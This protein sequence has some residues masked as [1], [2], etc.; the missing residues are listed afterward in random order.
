MRRIGL[1]SI[2]ALVTACAQAPTLA[3]TLS[4]EDSVVPGSIGVMVRQ[5][6]ATVIVTG[7]KTNGPAAAA[8]VRV[9]DVVLRLNGEPVTAPRQFYRLVVASPPGSVVRLELLRGGAV[10]VLEVPV[11][12][13]DTAPRV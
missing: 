11:Q 5:E 7:V 4:N 9:G 2:L 1:G 8:G 13:L 12:Q 10:E 6:H 3:P